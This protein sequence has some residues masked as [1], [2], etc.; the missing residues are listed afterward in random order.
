MKRLV[1][2][3]IVILISAQTVHAQGKDMLWKRGNGK[4]I[5]GEIR[6]VSPES[7]SIKFDGK[8]QEIP[9]GEIDRLIFSDDPAGLGAVRSAFKNGQLEQASRQ[10]A[11]VKASGRPFVQQDVDFYKAMIAAKLALRG[12]SDVTDAARDLGRFLK[13]NA[14]SFRFYEANEV[15]GDLAMSLGRFDSATKYYKKITKSKSSSLA[16]RGSL[17]LG[18]AWLLQGDLQQASTMFAR[19]NAAS[20]LRLRA[21]GELGLAVCQSET[22]Q[23]AEQALPRIEKVIAENDSS[24]VELFARAYNALGK[25]FLA[26]GK[27]ESALD[28]Y[29][30]T[31]LLFYRDSEKH[32]EALFQLS[33]LWTEVNKPAE[34]NKARQ[35]LTK[36]YASSVWAKR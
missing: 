22:A 16:A 26:T 17:L 23:G 20:D 6:Q 21:M 31:D 34:A 15:M 14:N 9:I 28:A 33:K 5:S 3:C 10:L 19:C 11:T 35:T 24:D 18:D 27:K 25:A 2:V 29:L 8:S 32:A 1:K 36:R 12:E 7:I 13:T 30:H 4:M